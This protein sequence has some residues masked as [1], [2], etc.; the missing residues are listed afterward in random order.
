MELHN[1]EI[2]KEQMAMEPRWNPEDADPPFAED[3][4]IWLGQM[5]DW[6]LWAIAT[7]VTRDGSTQYMFQA[8]AEDD[9]LF[10][11]P[12][13]LPDAIALWRR[14]LSRPGD[15]TERRHAELML[16]SCMRLRSMR[17]DV[18]EK[19][20]LEEFFGPEVSQMLTEYARV[21]KRIHDTAGLN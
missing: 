9:D 4:A 2:R 16:E 13:E 3:E 10:E 14:T 17:D 21:V 8:V 5:G 20:G 12:F 18:A 15:P 7:I 11:I 6:D 19:V 1:E